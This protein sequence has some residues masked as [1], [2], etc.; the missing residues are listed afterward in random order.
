MPHSWSRLPAATLALVFLAGCADDPASPR[1]S[2]E[3]TP[4]LQY[5]VTSEDEANAIPAVIDLTGE[6]DEREI[7]DI[8]LLTPEAATGIGTGSMLLITIPNE[9][10][11]GCSANFIWRTQSRLYLGSAGHCFLPSGTIATHGE[12]AD[13]DAS[14]VIVEVCVENCP[15]G[16]RSGA[17]LTGRFVRLGKV[18]YARQRNPENTTGVGHD[19][20]VVEIPRR[21]E[22]TIR[23]AMPVWGGPDGVDVLELGKQACHYGHGVVT[24]E[25]FV[26][27]GRTGVG[28]GANDVRWSGTFYA[29]FGDSG[30]GLVA[31]NT[32]SDGSIKG[33]GAIGVLTHLGVSTAAPGVIFEM[34]REA[35]LR[36]TLVQP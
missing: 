33:A 2:E 5:S 16:F 1:L 26:T 4:G 28:G 32:H 17:T 13:Y 7:I 14:G 12:N 18:A 6:A 36:L 19:F 34:A 10:R 31:C 21:I 8:E 23:P 25:T 22:E 3:A 20:G 27:K 15:N 30:S 35:K 29:A 11:F 9:G 24:G